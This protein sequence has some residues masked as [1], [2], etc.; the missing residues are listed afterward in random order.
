MYLSRILP[1]PNFLSISPP[2]DFLSLYPD[3]T[4]LSPQSSKSKIHFSSKSKM[5]TYHMKV[6]DRKYRGNGPKLNLEEDVSK[7]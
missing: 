7:T 3:P 1:H 5:T 4:P 2:T 6:G